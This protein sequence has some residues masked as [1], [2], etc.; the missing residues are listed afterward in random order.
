MY[1]IH[2]LECR[3]KSCDVHQSSTGS[4]SMVSVMSDMMFGVLDACVNFD[5]HPVS[6]VWESLGISAIERE[7]ILA[8]QIVFLNS[9]AMSSDAIIEAILSHSNWFNILLRVLDINEDTG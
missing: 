3:T 7:N 1:I 5:T 4:S 6:Q 2:V 8:N 9:L